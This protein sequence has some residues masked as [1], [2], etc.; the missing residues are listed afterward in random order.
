MNGLLAL[1]LLLDP[2]QARAAEPLPAPAVAARAVDLERVI[3]H[4]RPGM[5]PE[6]RLE[7]LR[8]WG[9]WELK[10]L[11]LIEGA[12]ASFPR[13]AVRSLS[14]LASL[15]EVTAVEADFEQEW[16]LEEDLP[17]AGQEIP[18]GIQRVNAL[19]AWSTARG[20][21]IKVAVVDTGVNL[22]HPDLK[23]EGGYNAI[24]DGASY[25]DDQGHGTHVAGTIAALDNAEGV[26][27][28]APQARIFAVKV[29]SA[30][31]GGTYGDIIDGIQWCVANSM[32]IIN[33][34]LG[35]PGGTSALAKAVKAAEKAGIVVVAA[36]GNGGAVV[37]PAGYPEV[38]AVAASDKGDKA[39][40]F[41]S[42]GPEVDF[43]APGVDIRSTGKG[44]GYSWKSGTSMAS[45]HL[46]GLAALAE[47]ARGLRGLAAVRKALEEA[48]TPLP[49]A[50]ADQQG[51][52]M[53]DA[54][55][56]VG[57]EPSSESAAGAVGLDKT[58]YSCSDRVFITVNAPDWNSDRDKVDSIG[59]DSEHP[60]RVSTRKGRLS[61]Y[62][63]SETGPD[64]GIFAGKVL[65][66]CSPSET[67]G[68]GPNDG[69][70]EAGPEDALT[71]SFKHSEGRILS[72]GAGVGWR[73]ASLS[74]DREDYAAGETARVRVADPDMDLDP[75]ALDRVELTV[76]SDSDLAGV[77]L[78]AVE[79]GEDTGEFSASIF[80]T[81]NRTSNGSRLF[82]RPGDGVH[83]VY[84]D[85]TPPPPHRPGDTL[86][87]EARARI[88][89]VPGG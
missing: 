32:D 4:F 42:R 84:F 48:A 40:D 22:S 7:L 89:R 44:Q 67:S 79:T 21:G 52:G 59:S 17:A 34:S 19:N 29:L 86:R 8:A 11:W 37:F 41:S 71:V 65:L 73:G 72:A 63:L 47:S 68:E 14:R 53:V 2:F 16:L 6:R 5:S 54:A 31:G 18:W 85:R 3:V 33:M 24:T 83:S 88:R 36:A 51:S 38:L 28:V 77:R 10:D 26:A 66:R 45:P 60:V 61:P 70:L 49:D 50:S 46:A 74:F 78:A 57:A 64:T 82:V 62:R 15:P 87:M 56:L 23:V 27:G 75:E 55:E 81:G 39:A 80:F 69:R 1:L 12:A 25:A 58:A 76:F 13:P 30:N 20:K 9:A 43:I 35:A